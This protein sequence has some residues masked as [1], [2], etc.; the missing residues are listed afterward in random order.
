MSDLHQS[1]LGCIT[2]GSIVDGL[3]QVA[4]QPNY[5]STERDWERMLAAIRFARELAEQPALQAVVDSE[6]LPG[7]KRQSDEALRRAIQAYALSIYHPVGTCR[8]ETAE[9]RPTPAVVDRQFRLIGTEGLRIADASILPDL[10]SCNTNAV[11][12]LVAERL[13][14][15]LAN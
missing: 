2:P 10:P 8:M 4:I 1:S 3:V 14:D 13:A 6:L 7:A 12:M 11:T 15:L 9:E 5:L